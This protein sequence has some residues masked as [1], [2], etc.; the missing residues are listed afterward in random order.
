[1]K[2]LAVVPSKYDTSP[3]QR[4]RIEQ[5]EPLLAEN[6]VEITYLPFETDELRSVLYQS[7]NIAQ[8]LKAVLA[9]MGARRAELRAVGEFD[10]VYIFREAAILGQPWFERKIAR[11]GVPIVFDFDDAVFVAYRSPS[12][13]YLSYLKFPQKT[14]EICGMSAHV[15]AGNEYLADYSRRYNENVSVIPTTID[16]D[17]YQLTEKLAGKS[18]LTIGWTGS[19]STVQHLDT[20]REA[21]Q[22]L[23]KTEDFVLRVIG[24]PVY[25]LDGVKVEAMQWRAESEI[26]DLREVD[27]GIMPLPDDQWSKGKCGLKALQYM[28][29]GVPTVCSPV[30]VNSTIIRDRE[31]GFL[32]DGKDEWVAVLK[33]LLHDGELRWRVG[34]AGRVTVEQG[35]SARSQAP[36]VYDVFQ[37]V[38]TKQEKSL[39][40]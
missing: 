13:G 36:R 6:G 16:T 2:V 33:R 3:G 29:L 8:K 5:W 23:A 25:E 4:F 40:V 21:L 12:N 17:K 9:S 27:I 26:D 18:P 11:S 28:A 32:A 20:L 35:Y 10:L 22:E 15:M 34:N 39:D 38:I 14:A 31:N 7:G 30:G 1:M 19:F 37:S 24:T